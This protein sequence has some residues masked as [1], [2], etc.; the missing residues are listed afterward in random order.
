M[1][2]MNLP[3]AEATLSRALPPNAPSADGL[4]GGA[5]ETPALRPGGIRP[6]SRCERYLQLAGYLPLPG[7]RV[8]I[9]RG[10]AL[11]LA[12]WN[13]RLQSVFAGELL[14]YEWV[15]HYVG[16]S[17]E[18]VQRRAD[19][20]ELTVFAFALQAGEQPPSVGRAPLAALRY[21][22]VPLQECLQWRIFLTSPGHSH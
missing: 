20:G 22:F 4:G 7:T 13:G 6:D 17:R 9:E 10:D 21:R 3:R 18:A 2:S 1:S 19:R 15:P 11:T 12:S 16:V 14:P 8:Y 5:T